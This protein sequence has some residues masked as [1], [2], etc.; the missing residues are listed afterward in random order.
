VTPKKDKLAQIINQLHAVG[1]VEEASQ[2]VQVRTQYLFELNAFAKNQGLFGY[3][4]A[5]NIHFELVGFITR[6]ILTN[7]MKLIRFEGRRVY[8]E[9]ITAMYQEGELKM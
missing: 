8:K 2:Q 1:S 6:G 7:T 9:A 5:K 3:Q 4:L